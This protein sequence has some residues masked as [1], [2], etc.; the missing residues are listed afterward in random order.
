MTSI[1]LN[2]G[3][4]FMA[5][6]FFYYGFLFFLK[7]FLDLWTSLSSP[8]NY[9]SLYFFLDFFIRKGF[10]VQDNHSLVNW[11]T[12]GINT[13]HTVMIQVKYRKP[14]QQTKKTEVNDK[15]K[16][17]RGGIVEAKTQMM[18]RQWSWQRSEPINFFLC[19]SDFFFPFLLSL[20]FF[21]FFFTLERE[22]SISK[23]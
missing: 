3:L 8:F 10:K 22:K 16:A 14:K 23:K 12:E 17:E 19:G 6:C 18:L 1:S 15:V 13:L 20:F 4:F 5:S 21:F 9:L 11:D 2:L 7:K